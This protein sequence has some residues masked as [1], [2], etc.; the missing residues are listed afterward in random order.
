MDVKLRLVN[1][2]R[3]SFFCSQEALKTVPIFRERLLNENVN[4]DFVVENI[5]PATLLF[6]CEFLE[7]MIIEP[8]PTIEFSEFEQC[9]PNW[10]IHF[11]DKEDESIADLIN[12]G[13]KWNIPKLTELCM[14]H[15]RLQGKD[16]KQ[17]LKKRSFKT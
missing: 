14:M 15:F 16:Y 6:V 2:P 5:E 7:Q 10:Y 9:T 3:L 12:V 8:L 17:I 1:Y 13:N 11:L 4:S